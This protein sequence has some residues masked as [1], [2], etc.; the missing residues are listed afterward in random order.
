MKFKKIV[1]LAVVSTMLLGT[2]A[3]TGC[4]KKVNVDQSEQGQKISEYANPDAVIS[5]KGL[6]QLIDAKDENLVII[7]VID[8]KKAMVPG[9]IASGQIEGSYIVWRPDYS[10]KGS[11]EAISEEVGGIRKSKEHMEELLSKAGATDKS[12]IVVYSADAHHDAARLYWQIKLLGHKDVKYLDG[13]LN[14]WAGAEFPTGN[15]KVLV[16]EN[17]KT[18]YKAA[19]YKPETMDVTID[20]LVEALNNPDEWVIIDTRSAGEYNGEQTGSSKGAFGTG[21]IKGSTH[22]EWTNA[23]DEETT[24]LK[25]IDELKRIYGDTIKDK[26][27]I[28]FCQSG[29]RS[30]HTFLV[31]KEVLGA[32]EVYNYDGS[33]I[34]WSYVASEASKGKVADEIRT[35]VLNL[36]EIWTDNKVEIN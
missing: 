26:K 6:K 13:G 35:A 10:G 14:A 17:V 32:K 29:V 20:K 2:I 7:G 30:G 5:P 31:L 36:T 27:V 33:W 22:I 15:G 4:G 12:T 11:K 25:S 24:T 16:D 21:R 8:P 28:A 1:A 18:E 34:E 19:S 9:S 23:V 3:L